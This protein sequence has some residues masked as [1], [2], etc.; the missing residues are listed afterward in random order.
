MVIALAAVTYVKTGETAALSCDITLT[1]GLTVR[2]AAW[3]KLGPPDSLVADLTGTAPAY[4]GRATVNATGFLLLDNVQQADEGTYRCDAVLSNFSVPMPFQNELQI[5]RSPSKPTATVPSPV[6]QGSTVQLTCE[7]NDAGNPA[8]SFVWLKGGVAIAT[9]PRHTYS[10]DGSVLTISNVQTGDGGS[11][12][13]R[14]ENLAGSQTSVAKQ[15][16][17]YYP[18]DPPTVD[19]TGTA[20]YAGSPLTVNCQTS[21]GN[22][23]PTITWYR[24][25]SGGVEQQVGTA[26]QG[27][28]DLVFDPLTADDNDDRYVCKATNTATQQP[29]VDIPSQ[30]ITLLVYYPPDTPT[31]SYTGA[32]VYADT[33]LTVTCET[34]TGNPTPTLTWYQL[35]SGG[36][37]QQVGTAGNLVFNPLTADN[38]GDRYVCKATN[39]ATQQPGVDDPSETITLLVY[40]PPDEVTVTYDGSPVLAGE[41]FS[42]TCTADTG[43][44]PPTLTWYPSGSDQ[45]VGTPG[46]GSSL[47]QIS[48]LTKDDN[49]DGYVCEAT[50]DAT[51]DSPPSKDI[52]LVVHYSPTITTITPAVTVDEFTDVSL[53]CTADSNPP[54]TSFTWTYNGAA[55]QTTPSGDFTLSTSRT[56][57]THDQAGTYTCT[58]ANG[59]PDSSTEVSRDTVVTVEFPPKF[60][61]PEVPY[62][63]ADGDTV[64]LTC[65]AIAESAIT[66]MKWIHD[67][68]VLATGGQFTVTQRSAGE[69]VLTIADVMEDNYGMYNCTAQNT[70][71]LRWSSIILEAQGPPHAPT[72]F[73]VVTKNPQGAVTVQWSAG[74]NGG[75][76][77]THTVDYRKLGD[78]V[79]TSGDTVTQSVSENHKDYSVSLQLG[80]QGNFTIRLRTGNGAGNVPAVTVDVLIEGMFGTSLKSQ[81]CL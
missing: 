21:T 67:G 18:P 30:T 69:S 49:G 42:A 81:Q 20:V 4:S 38:N 11:Y 31:V 65:S 76:V 70:K 35:T 6:F 14:A 78:K 5:A 47:L 36:G 46:T 19:Y 15:M 71:G 22:P 40:Y 44:P 28:S 34:N 74:F 80:S 68:Q 24:L 79:W 54:P 10:P 33:D 48:P 37:E 43:N 29:G 64:N 51:G 66:E 26:G 23:T 53:S 45:A 8:A 9:G 50:N 73:H 77:T 3:T 62:T 12:S 13:C 17:V 7:T 75:L 61:H 55:L 41:S 59:I 63:A 39:M 60:T 1:G 2:S 57:I 32:A 58:V 16:D 72:N 25:T 56:R 52:T 27:S